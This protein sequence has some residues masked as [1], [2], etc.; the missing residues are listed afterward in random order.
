MLKW[1]GDPTGG[2]Y[3]NMK[4]GDILSRRLHATEEAYCGNLTSIICVCMQLEAAMRTCPCSHLLQS[5]RATTLELDPSKIFESEI[6]S[7][8]H[9][10]V[11]NIREIDA[12][13]FVL[14]KS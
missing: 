9:V 4:N 2:L 14:T 1:N 3:I 13:A 6:F 5:E 12:F 8:S 10:S 11:K 7:E